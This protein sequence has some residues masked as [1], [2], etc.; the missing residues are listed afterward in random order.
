MLH[1]H[2]RLSSKSLIAN[3]DYHVTAANKITK[4]KPH[5][6]KRRRGQPGIPPDSQLS[7]KFKGVRDSL[8]KQNAQTKMRRLHSMHKEENITYR[9]H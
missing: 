3:A 5:Q 2:L 9:F 4:S 7:Y 8:V 1:V 6:A